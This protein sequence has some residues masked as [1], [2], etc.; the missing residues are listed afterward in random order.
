MSLQLTP[1]SLSEANAFIKRFHRHH[2]SVVG[3]KFSI[4]ASLNNKIVAIVIVGRPVSRYA[5][6]GFTL[7]VTRLCTDGTHNACSILY[8]AAWRASKAMGYK[9]LITYTLPSE[10]GASLRASNF[11]LIGQ[12][13]GGSWNRANRPRID[14]HPLQQKL[15]W[16]AK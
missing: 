3:H 9:Q 7:E 1:V 15:K 2:K 16:S 12:C 13:G 5:D 11:K 4:A 8:S 6:N 14:K 10:G